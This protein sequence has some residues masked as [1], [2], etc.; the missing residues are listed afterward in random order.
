MDSL[1]SFVTLSALVAF[2][3]RGVH[4]AVSFIG[5]WSPLNVEY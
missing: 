1:Y 3:A 4:S 2:P 5:H